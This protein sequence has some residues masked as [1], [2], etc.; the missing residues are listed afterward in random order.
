V[1][2]ELKTWLREKLSS[3]NETAKA[4]DYSLKRWPAL[5]RLLDDGRLCISNNAAERAHRRRASRLDVKA[6]GSVKTSHSSAQ[7]C[8]IRESLNPQ[9]SGFLQRISDNQGQDH[10]KSHSNKKLA[11]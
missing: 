7:M 5:T 11:F 6:C 3:K 2:T 9:I 10:Q 1:I 8:S 4:I